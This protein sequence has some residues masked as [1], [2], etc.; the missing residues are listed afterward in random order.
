MRAVFNPFLE[1]GAHFPKP[2]AAVLRFHESLP[3]YQPTPLHSLPGLARELGIGSLLVKDE[4]ARFGLNAF[5]ALG[6]SWAVHRFLERNGGA[7]VTFASA[8]DGNH[9]RAVA[10]AARLT[11]NRAVIYVPRHTVRARIDAIRGEG[12]E[13][14]V[15][16]GT[17]DDAVRRADL[18]SRI[19]GWQV[20]SDTAYP[21]HMEIPAWVIEGYSTM[22]VEIEPVPDIVIVQ[23]G[24]GGLA[25]AAVQH[26][27]GARLVC[28]Q[29]TEADGL[30]ESVSSENGEPRSTCNSQRTI[31]AGLACGM[32]SLLAWPVLKRGV[33]L[34]LSVDDT[35]AAEAMRRLHPRI[36]SGET[37]AAGLAG[38]IALCREPEFAQSKEQL[39][40]SSESSVLVISTEG[41]T[42][43]ENY[44]AI[45]R[46][47]AHPGANSRTT[48]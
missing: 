4:S 29:P 6:A 44:R 18:D 9:G 12:A 26:F 25:A 46:P 19:N 13:V 15:V 42:D 38:L 36:I 7:R 31:M 39:G 47:L 2:D 48:L 35:F 17:Y 40:L 30:L 14:I 33:T 22:F 11:G 10:W 28:V 20:I 43:P 23:A 16:D 45:V 24:V 8:T 34:F 1:R 5:K 41:D 3:G 32:P 27:L 21:G 37:G